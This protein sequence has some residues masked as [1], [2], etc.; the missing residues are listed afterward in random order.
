MS[1]SRQRFYGRDMR[2]TR[3]E[4]AV[5]LV[6][7]GQ[8]GVL[9]KRGTADD[10]HPLDMPIV[11]PIDRATL[12]KGVHYKEVQTGRTLIL[13]GYE[14]LARSNWQRTAPSVLTIHPTGG[15]FAYYTVDGGYGEEGY[16]VLGYGGYSA[17]A[18]EVGY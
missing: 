18:I 9:V 1:R 10:K 8:T 6:E 2:T 7:D 17:T 13:V 3:L 5:S 14:A 15:T 4:R 11:P 12:K 16:G